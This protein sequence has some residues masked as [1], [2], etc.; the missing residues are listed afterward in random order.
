MKAGGNIKNA[1]DKGWYFEDATVAA[2]IELTK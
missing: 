2:T 1:T